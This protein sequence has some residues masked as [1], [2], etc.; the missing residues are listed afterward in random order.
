MRLHAKSTLLIF[1]VA[2]FLCAPESARPQQQ[3]S[4]VAPSHTDSMTGMNMQ[5]GDHDSADSGAADSA[6]ETMSSTHMDTGPHM[7]MTALRPPTAADQARAAQLATT[8]RQSIEKYRDYHVALADGFKIFLPNVPQEH[9]HFTNYANALKAQFVFDATRPTSLLYKKT[10][11]GY[12]LEGAMYTAPRSYTENQLNQRVPL[13]VARWHEHVNLC[14]PPKGTPPR[15]ADWT[16]FG[17][18][19]SIATEASC[20]EAGGRWHPI[21]LNWMVHVYPFETD[22]S[23]VWAH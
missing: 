19:G 10:A 16:K 11:D 21:I 1:A 12:K 14:S 15:D 9:Y 3:N 2:A 8:L 6:N 7:Y 18:R 5:E 22:P 4:A 17:L 13:S 23:K 20:V